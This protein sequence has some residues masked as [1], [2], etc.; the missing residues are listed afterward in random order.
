MRWHI[1]AC[2]GDALDAKAE[3]ITFEMQLA[4]A[5]KLAE[6]SPAGS[7]L[8]NMLDRNVH[9]Q[10]AQVVVNAWKNSKI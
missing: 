8:P 9:K 6:L 10:V 5:Y 7:L 1:P 4:T 2:S 3:D